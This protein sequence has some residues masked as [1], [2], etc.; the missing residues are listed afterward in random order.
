MAQVSFF[1]VTMPA[2]GRRTDISLVAKTALHSM[3]CGKKQTTVP[4]HQ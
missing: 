2:F 4:I 1:F 3:Q